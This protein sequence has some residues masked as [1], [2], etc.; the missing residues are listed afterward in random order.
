MLLGKYINKYYA[1]YWY[2]F[3]IGIIALVSL[4]YVQLFEP[5]FLGRIVD[6]LSGE[7]EPDRNLIISLCGKLLIV[8]GVMFAGR[9]AWRYTLFNASSRIEAGLRREMFLKAERL[10]QGYYHT[11][12]TGS[13]MSWFTTDLET[14]EEYTGFG[15][16]QMVDAFFLG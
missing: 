10:S 13:I 9:M 4:D 5:E 2:F 15:T 14:I 16:V 3:L 8:A 12:K 1:R 7:G 11:T 6:E